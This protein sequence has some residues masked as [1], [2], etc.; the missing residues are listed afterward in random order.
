[1]SADLPE[2]E[3]SQCGARSTEVFHRKMV[4]GIRC[5]ICGHERITEDRRTT[6][7]GIGGSDLGAYLYRPEDN[8]F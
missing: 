1:M 7:G 4:S 6:K 8:R 2:P 3:C 5:L